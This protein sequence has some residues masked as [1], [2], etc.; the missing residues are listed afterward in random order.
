MATS[1]KEKA[2]SKQPETRA[3]PSRRS[4]L[5]AVL[6]TCVGVVAVQVAVRGGAAFGLGLLV[7]FAGERRASQHTRAHNLKHAPLPV[8]AGA[9]ESSP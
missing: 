2:Q 6:L 5:G 9:A 7:E 3:A 1:I 4:R 8:P